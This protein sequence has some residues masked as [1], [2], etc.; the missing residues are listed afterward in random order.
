M[1]KI[2][3]D[4]K[5]TY[6]VTV[7]KQKLEELGITKSIDVKITVSIE[8][9]NTVSI[10][11]HTQ[12]KDNTNTIET[13]KLSMENNTIRIP[14]KLGEL[15]Q[16]KHGEKITWF[17]NTDKNT[18]KL[19]FIENKL[20]NIYEI[21]ELKYLS[22]QN[23]TKTNHNVYISSNIR[24]N[25]LKPYSGKYSLEYVK[26]DNEFGIRFRKNAKSGLQTKMKRISNEYNNMRLYIP[27]SIAYIATKEKYTELYKDAHGNL[28]II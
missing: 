28:I 19:Y 24:E 8:P 22:S 18:L 14:N 2:Q 12:Y 15:L 17:T 16:L 3:K 20:I 4:T 26:V 13:R 7:E 25:K 23:I 11:F 27:K 1:Y 21:D 6:R 10:V 5:N 9:D